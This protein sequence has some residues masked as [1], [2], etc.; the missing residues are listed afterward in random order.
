[1]NTTNSKSSLKRF[2]EKLFLIILVVLVFLLIRYG[3]HMLLVL[4]ASMMLAILWRGIGWW[5]HDKTG[6]EQGWA[7]AGTVIINLAFFGIIGWLLWPSVSDQINALATEL[8][9]AAK[10]VETSVRD[11]DVGQLILRQFEGQQISSEKLVQETVKVL[12]GILSVVVDFFV[13]IVLAIFLTANPHWYTRGFLQLI[14]KQKRRRAKEVLGQLNLTLFR[15]FIG[16][17]LD[18]TSIFILTSLGLWLL[19]M[20]LVLTL[21]LIAFFLSFIPNIGPILSAVPALAIAFLQEPMMAVWVGMLYTGI[22]LFESYFIT[23]NIQKHAIQMPPVLLLL[24][25]LL[26][27]SLMG[28]LGLLLATPLLASGIVLVRMLYVEDV[29]GEDPGTM[30]ED[31][32]F[33]YDVTSNKASEAP[34]MKDVPPKDEE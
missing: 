23:P 26:A 15:W 17:I 34:E 30:P 20:P 13:I 11:S 12:N 27:A 31:G 22:Q 1:M 24:V 28:V 16:K 4:F 8:P 18:M 21:S 7:V 9:E 14:P 5:V 19:G 29:L 33:Q 25:Q 6:L 10:I 3:I 2:S 32:E